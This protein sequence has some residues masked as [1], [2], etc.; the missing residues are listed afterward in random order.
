MGGPEYFADLEPRKAVASSKQF[1]WKVVWAFIFACVLIMIGSGTVVLLQLR[2]IRGEIR[3]LKDELT[4][5]RQ[6]VAKAEAKLN[7]VSPEAR[8]STDR[9]EARANGISNRPD[10]PPFTLSREEVQVIRDF[11]KVPPPRRGVT[12]N[13]N[14]GD[15]VSSAGLASLPELVMEKIPKLRGAR[16][17]VDRSGAIIIAAPGSNRADLIIDPS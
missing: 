8:G 4:I 17:T 3:G 10:P 15:V 2:N 6:R 7:A 5:V 16:F 14:V 13:I 12:R 1:D 9:T 11:I